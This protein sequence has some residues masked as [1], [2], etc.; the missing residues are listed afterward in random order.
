M[1]IKSWSM[2]GINMPLII[3]GQA[4]WGEDGPDQPTMESKV[5]N[6]VS[7]FA[8]WPQILG[9]SWYHAGKKDSPPDSMS[10]AMIAAIKHSQL[11]MKP[12]QQPPAAAAG[13]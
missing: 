4:Y 9:F 13:A 5:A 6:F 8:D 1:T 3:A 7:N 2:A 10:D 12:Y 11:G